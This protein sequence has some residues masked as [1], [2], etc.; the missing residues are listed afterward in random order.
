MPKVPK[1]TSQVVLLAEQHACLAGLHL[2]F[3][4]FTG[5]LRRRLHGGEERA[6]GQKF[7]RKGGGSFA[8]RRV[9]FP[10]E[11]HLQGSLLAA[12]ESKHAED[13]IGAV[14]GLPPEVG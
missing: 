8:L 2:A 12:R 3:T 13:N 1:T 7:P 6:P 14:R 11:R 5:A 10:P 4:A 9:R